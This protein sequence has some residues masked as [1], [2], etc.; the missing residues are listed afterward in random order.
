MSER[1][2]S[3]EQVLAKYLTT[4]QVAEYLQVPVSTLHQWRYLGKGPRAARVGKHLRY[5]RSD[6]D[7]WFD[8]Q[9]DPVTAA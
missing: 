1:L 5:R 2:L 9:T 6:V 7:A 4:E 3:T 8:K